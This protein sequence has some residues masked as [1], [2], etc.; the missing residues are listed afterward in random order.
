MTLDKMTKE[1]LVKE[2]QKLKST[3]ASENKKEEIIGS[4]SAINDITKSMQTEKTLKEEKEFSDAIINTSHA[5][6]IGL[7]KNHKIKIFSYGAEIITGY[8]KEEV[9]EK[10]WFKLFFKPEMLEEMNRVWEDSWGVNFHS[11]ENPI[12]VKNGQ[13]KIISW[14]S[15]GFHKGNDK[16]KHLQI[17]IGEDITDRKKAEAK[18]FSRENYLSALNEAKELLLTSESEN[19]SVYQ[20][21]VDILG[22]A[23]KA[24]RTYIFLNHTNEKGQNL[25][26]QKVEYCSQGI[27][28]HITNS[29]LQN[30][31]YDNFFKR[32]QKKLAKGD[33]I[34]GKIEDF[35]KKEKEI[36]KSWEIKNI[37]LFPI[38]V[39][40]KSIGF[41]GF[42][43]C[44]S[45]RNWDETERNYLKSAAQDLAQFIIIKREKESLV[46]EHKRFVTAMNSLSETVSVTDI[47]THKI[48]FANNHAKHLFG[49]DIVGKSCWQVFRNNS[50][51]SCA[52]CGIN[53]LIDENGLARKPYNWDLFNPKTNKWYSINDQAIEWIDGRIVRLSMATDITN[54]KLT[55]EKLKHRESYLA[56]LNE[57]K[58][59]LLVSEYES[60]N[61]FQQFVDI[62]G[63]ASKASRT[64][65]FLNHTDGKGELLMSQKAEYCAKGI[66]PEVNN[67]DLQN[68]KYDEF[69][70]RWQA[71]LSKGELI[72]GKI[73]D[74]PK[75]EKEFLTVQNIKAI[76]II[77]IV[78]DKNFI[79][80]IGY[81]N[82]VSEREWDE[83]ERNYLHSAA[84]DLA[85][86]III[87]REKEKLLEEHKRFET[88]MNSL[89]VAVYVADMHTYEI[90]FVNNYIKQ[91]F[92]DNLV[93]KICW[94][95]FHDDFSGPC[96][97]CTND[98]L[99]DKNGDFKKSYDWEFF[100]N[101]LNKWFAINNQAIKWIDG[102]TV[103]L[104][105]ATD[106]TIRK[107]AEKEVA[108]RQ[109]KQSL[110]INSMP[111]PVM[112]IN[113]KRK[114]LALNDAAKKMEIKCNDYCWKEF[115]KCES[116]SEKNKIRAKNN[117]DNPE[118]KCT[119]C[120]AD[121][122]FENNEIRN[123]PKV[124]SFGGFFDTY[125]VPLDK[126][127]FLHYAIDVTDKQKATE[128]LDKYAR[129]Q[130][131][132]LREVNHRVKNNLYALMGMLNK[133]KNL[134]E[135]NNSVKQ[136]EF[137]D[138]ILLKINSLSTVHSL[139]S[140]SK[141]QP[142]NLANLCRELIEPL[143][144][145]I[146]LNESVVIDIAPTEVKVSSNQAHHITIVINEII[147]N[148]IKYALP[149][150][151]TLVLKIEI[152]S[153]GK[154]I[155][156]R[157]KDNGDGFPQS[158]LDGNFEN[159]RI[160]FELIFG[161]VKESLAGNVFVEN[162]NGAVFN[163]TFKNEEK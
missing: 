61:T 58:E 108:Q 116:L 4:V 31:N 142:I 53:K 115:G 113:K 84:Q 14:Q 96:A 99:L 3:K 57:A 64:Y 6:I 129:T 121:K 140:A 12:F 44:I 130:E 90:L 109:R 78:V 2:I 150:K 75:K 135:K 67:P 1:Q 79:G 101:K 119:F 122:M 110:L 162:N 98:K 56:A 36:L 33:S 63:S 20:Q 106:I 154:N 123:D 112:L 68:L 83:A 137:I 16:S 126:D 141:W 152:K 50:T 24:S 70:K 128:K 95:T 69:F 134:F 9:L 49:F 131:V 144:D 107:E 35:P 32:W 46:A 132:L 60:E 153:D 127:L 73:K 88:V 138:N 25:I 87:K 100:N 22:P 118:I 18:L 89:D 71:T 120:Q 161:I 114:I 65:I 76:L 15:T 55:E 105:I 158:I 13:K 26:S 43:N 47:Q 92:N 54:H 30:L 81:D 72:F 19:I 11:Y 94:Q 59:V 39:D 103:R 151:E 82:C 10:D 23:S 91:L 8:S 80:F 48:L 145:S 29:E 42:D 86:F 74:F 37:I 155:I 97:F 143:V 104:E 34:F 5:I 62:L 27:S 21:F 146:A 163:I 157:I 136:S 38:I 111:Y 93:G 41:I 17:S 124:E 102:K 148:A 45:E 85:Q 147:T 125:W 77:P 117:P 7:D 156:I 139:L 28:S 66:K 40:K 51:K 133:E 160:G 149:K 52:S 159:S